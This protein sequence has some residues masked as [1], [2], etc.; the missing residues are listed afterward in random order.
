M[1]LGAGAWDVC[2]R[3]GARRDLLE[4]ARKRMEEMSTNSL[5]APL[6]KASF[7]PDTILIYGNPAQIMRLNQAWSYMSGER[8]PGRFGGKVKCDEYLIAPFK[9]HSACV[10]IHEI[11]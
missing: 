2:T 5:L 1:D 4:Q 7:N 8:V 10:V 6:E 3:G 11:F 9:T